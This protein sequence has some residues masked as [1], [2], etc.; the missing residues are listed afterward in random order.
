MSSQVLTHIIRQ[1]LQDYPKILLLLYI[2]FIYEKFMYVHRSR[3]YFY[4]LKKSSSK[5]NSS[6]I[7]KWIKISNTKVTKKYQ[8][9][10]A[11]KM[12]EIHDKQLRLF[13]AYSAELEDH[14]V[15]NRMENTKVFFRAK[16]DGNSCDILTSKA[17]VFLKRNN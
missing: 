17:D 8:W 12:L 15:Q 7:E 14:H 6:K 11:S 10:T 4:M 5:G 2:F 9:R 3:N 13:N 16:Q 1:R